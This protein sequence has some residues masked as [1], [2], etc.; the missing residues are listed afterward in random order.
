[1]IAGVVLL[2]ACTVGTSSEE[3]ASTFPSGDQ[4][5]QASVPELTTTSQ[6]T[7]TTEQVTTTLETTQT[8]Q[9]PAEVDRL[10]DFVI[11]ASI[12]E[13]YD[14]SPFHVEDVWGVCPL[15]WVFPMPQ[16]RHDGW[17]MHEL[18]FRCDD[19]SGM[20]VVRSEGLDA[21]S[22]WGDWK[23]L[24]GEDAYEGLEGGGKA[25]IDQTLDWPEIYY[26][27]E[28]NPPSVTGKERWWS[29]RSCRR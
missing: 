26:Y 25:H 10:E 12:D 8:T 5:V 23:I 15:G 20:W 14:I 1:L 27:G 19:G 28:L 24:Y 13:E 22:P 16:Q 18:V 7:T 29:G 11:V 17:W 2:A 9:I 21:D 6:V 3:M 4:H